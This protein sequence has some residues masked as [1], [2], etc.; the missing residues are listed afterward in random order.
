MM[1]TQAAANGLVSMMGRM[2]PNGRLNGQGRA[3]QADASR[4]L[5]Y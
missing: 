4:L 1:A 2:L 5:Q 3:A